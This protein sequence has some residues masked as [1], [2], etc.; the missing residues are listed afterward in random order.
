MNLCSSAGVVAFSTLFSILWYIDYRLEC[1]LLYGKLCQIAVP[2]FPVLLKHLTYIYISLFTWFWYI[3]YGVHNLCRFYY[4]KHYIFLQVMVNTFL[5][6]I[7]SR[8]V[9]YS[10]YHVLL[11]FPRTHVCTR[12]TRDWNKL[13]NS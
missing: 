9:F 7:V 6:M 13:P 10:Y 1:I 12:L 8:S 5:P 2:H 3:Q 4:W 11:W